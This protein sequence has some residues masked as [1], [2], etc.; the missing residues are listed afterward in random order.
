MQRNNRGQRYGGVTDMSLLSLTRVRLWT[1]KA[2]PIPMAGRNG[3]KTKIKNG[4][5]A[6]DSQVRDEYE[7]HYF[8]AANSRDVRLTA[9]FWITR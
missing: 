8:T 2:E 7:K 3:V 9:L 5:S 4:G 6:S 1:I